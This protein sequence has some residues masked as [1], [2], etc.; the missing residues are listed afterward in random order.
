LR[1]YISDRR[2]TFTYDWKCG[3]LDIVGPKFGGLEKYVLK[4]LSLLCGTS[5][6][7]V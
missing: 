3:H 6:G 5:R 7:Y 2:E 4:F 1:R